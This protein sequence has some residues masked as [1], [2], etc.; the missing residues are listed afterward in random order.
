MTDGLEEP[1][2]ADVHGAGSGASW[3]SDDDSELFAVHNDPGGGAGGGTTAVFGRCAHIVAF[4]A[5]F[6]GD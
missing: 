6:G 1:A 2:A 4:A 5:A 3:P